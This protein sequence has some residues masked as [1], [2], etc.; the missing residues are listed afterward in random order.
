MHKTD[1]DAESHIAQLSQSI[2]GIWG[3]IVNW[4]EGQEGVRD[5]GGHFCHLN[6]HSCSPSGLLKTSG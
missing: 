6:H 5:S 2:L 4:M 3:S 1:R